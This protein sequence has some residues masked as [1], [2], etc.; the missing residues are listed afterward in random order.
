MEAK[1]ITLPSGAILKIT[2]A[3]FSEA[4]ALYQAFLEELRAM[5]LDPQADIDVNLFKDLACAG[6]SSKRIEKCLE[7]CMERAMYND[8]QLRASD[9]LKIFEPVE[10]R[11][12]Y[13]M[14]CFEVAKEN[15]A[16]FTKSL[17]AEWSRVLALLKNDQQPK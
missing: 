4:R 17:Y 6:F 10:A 1:Q 13:I 16:P 12:D 14:V 8:N 15:I 11:Q 2:P 5:K 3:P 7:A 9:V